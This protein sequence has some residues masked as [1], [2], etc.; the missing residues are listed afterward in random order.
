MRPP[1]RPLGLGQRRQKLI[2]PRIVEF[3]HV[4]LS[5]AMMLPSDQQDRAVFARDDA[6]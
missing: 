3:M 4:S 2:F 6:R 1:L 5:V